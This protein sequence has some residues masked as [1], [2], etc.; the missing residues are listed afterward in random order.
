MNSNLIYI[1]FSASNIVMMQLCLVQA[2]AKLEGTY[3]WQI[4]FI[5]VTFFSRYLLIR[6]RNKSYMEKMGKQEF[7]EMLR[8]EGKKAGIERKEPF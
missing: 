2:V 7:M 6:I 1:I 3:F 5:S 8:E 4:K